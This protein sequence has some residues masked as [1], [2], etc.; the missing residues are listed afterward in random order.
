MSAGIII[1]I[2]LVLL[3]LLK[4]YVFRGMYQASLSKVFT[5][6]YFVLSALIFFIGIIVFYQWFTQGASPS[7]W[8]NFLSALMFTFTV[9]ELIMSAV[10]L[11][12]DVLIF[13]SWVGDKFSKKEVV[14]VVTE[15]R[16]FVKLAGLGLAAIP[17]ASFLYG[18][19]KGK[20]AYK[21]Y[22][23]KL[24]FKDLPNSF[25]GFKLV[26]FSD[27]HSG[28]FDSLESVQRGVELMQDQMQI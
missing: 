13:F 28:S 3:F 17:F 15:R 24:A 25:D 14:E 4:L 26:Q 19:T 6:S 22:R 11:L 10:F 2:V 5:W 12:D 7:F 16:R 1:S 20:Y 18:I 21:V 23:V 9:V 8:S 27:F